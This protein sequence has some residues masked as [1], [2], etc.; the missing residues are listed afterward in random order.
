M[1]MYKKIKTDAKRYIF[2]SGLVTILDAIRNI[3]VANLMG[4]YYTGLCSTLMIMPQAS[5]YLNLGL[6]D[7]LPVIIPKNRAENNIEHLKSIKNSIFSITAA[8]SCVSFIFSVIYGLII[9]DKGSPVPFYFV[10]AGSLTV[11]WQMKK[12]FLTIYVAEDNFYKFNRMELFFSVLVTVIQV[13]AVYLYREYGFWFGFIIPYIIIIIF[14]ARDYLRHNALK[15]FNF[16]FREVLQYVPLGISMAAYGMTYI[17]FI[18]LSKLFLAGTVGIQE[19]GLFILSTIIIPRISI[20]PASIARVLL[21][22]ISY[23]GAGKSNETFSFDLFIKV[24]IC[25]F[26][27]TLVLF[28]LGFVLLEP[29]VRMLMPRYVSGI[30]SAKMILFAALPYCLIDNAN[31]VLLTTHHKRIFFLNLAS[32]ISLQLVLLLILHS[33]HHLSAYSASASLIIVF[34]Y[35]AI[36]SNY[37]TIKLFLTNL[38]D[39]A[40]E[41][42]FLKPM[43]E[44]LE[45]RLEI[46]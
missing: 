9:A 2:T 43:E 31:I 4:P 21:P 12:F 22:K 32:A 7:A 34:L 27:L 39:L 35:L 6:L 38:K 19:V 36:I 10:L 25:T 45:G 11:L 37:K 44:E 8:V 15:L 26:G 13:V 14:A 28:A 29:A 16:N 41:A 24:Q 40:G 1:H 17:P 33:L 18:I 46:S 30:P 5:Q 20:I 3:S 42:P 23:A